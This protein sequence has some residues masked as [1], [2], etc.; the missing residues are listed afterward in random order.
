MR[1]ALA[2]VVAVVM[3]AAV[4]VT[5]GLAGSG[6]PAPA[7]QQYV[8]QIPTATG[9]SSSGAEP[10]AGP[11]RSGNDRIGT[12]TA[13]GSAPALPPTVEARLRKLPKQAARR[14]RAIATSPRLGAQPVRPP[15]RPALAASTGGSG[16]LGIIGIVA[17]AAIVAAA[18]GAVATRRARP[19]QTP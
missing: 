10:T 5:P 16:E 1:T 7:V 15:R 4:G 2:T 18:S 14:L 3:T 19:R 9:A 13:S 12:V 11:S 17:A 6:A 8:E